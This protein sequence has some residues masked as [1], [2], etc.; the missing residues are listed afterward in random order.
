MDVQAMVQDLWNEEKIA[1][2]ATIA[3]DVLDTYFAFLRRWSSWAI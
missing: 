2:S 1:S 3:C